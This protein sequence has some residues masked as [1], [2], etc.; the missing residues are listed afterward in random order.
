[1]LAAHVAVLGL[2]V[3]TQALF[4]VLAV[5]DVR[6]ADRTVTAEREWLTGQ[7]GVEDP[8]ELLDY[9]RTNAGLSELRSWSLLA[10]V[11]LVVYGFLPEAVAAVEGL[12]LG[13][14]ASG[15]L[16][17]AGATVFLRVVA[18]PFDAVETFVVEETFGFNNQSV[19]LWARDR[20]VGLVVALA[21]A[22]VLGAALLVSVAA[23]P[24]LW[25]LAAV[26]LFVGFS[27]AIQVLYPRVIAPLFYEFE[28][29]EGEVR[30]AVEDVFERAG[31][32]CEQVYEM[33]ASQRS[34][35]SNAYFVGFGRTKR[36]VL[37]DTLLDQMDRAEIQSVLA[38]ELAHWKRAHVWKG[39]A[40]STARVAVVVGALYVLAT[41]GWFRTAFSIPAG[42]DYAAIA[43][44][45]LATLPLSRLL[46][47]LENRLSLRFERE[48]DAFAVDVMEAG[49]PLVDALAELTS[50]NLGNPFPHPW[51]A[52]FH[53][54]HPPVPE[55][56]RTIR[57]RAGEEGDAP[58]PTAAD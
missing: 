16:F 5:L 4:T 53:H 15:V 11:L 3:G 55:R 8:A 33:D 49:D 12:G 32:T 19:R 41:A 35:H 21:F 2:L 28:P 44:A 43:V 20:L 54:V 36:V 30:D 24:G 45:A 13:P 10:V 9:H 42:A 40:A 17:F 37:F 29:L 1:M 6:H 57:E 7:L 47:P 34:G 48:A 31:F 27:L 52:A 39:L 51:Y 18:L 56:I 58:E 50:E 23:L 38:H 14:V 25:W 22:A 46:A 26:G